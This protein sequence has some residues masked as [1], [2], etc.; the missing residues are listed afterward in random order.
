MRM[1]FGRLVTTSLIA[2]MAMFLLLVP[3][4]VGGPGS[5]GANAA[6]PI[7]SGAGV[8]DVATAQCR[9]ISANCTFTLNAA[10]QRA[11]VAGGGAAASGALSTACGPGAVGC[12]AAAAAIGA[13]AAGAI[14]GQV[15]DECIF[16]IRT[17]TL[18]AIG[19]AGV[20]V[21]EARQVCPPEI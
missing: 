5:G 7:V 8:V 2:A 4:T 9:G 6:L 13:A 18:G 20:I 21:T 14:G 10:E 17:S 16:L 1:Y 12:Y 19:M 3:G 15:R 11:I